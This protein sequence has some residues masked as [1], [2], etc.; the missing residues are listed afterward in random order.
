MLSAG[1]AIGR[2]DS[3]GLRFAAAR[4]DLVLIVG[5]P[6]TVLGDIPLK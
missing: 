6:A 5:T 2:T 1:L 3:A 4:P